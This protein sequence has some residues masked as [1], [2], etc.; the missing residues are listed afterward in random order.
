LGVKYEQQ[1]FKVTPYSSILGNEL[2]HEGK[3]WVSHYGYLFDFG[4]VKVY[5]SGDLSKEATDSYSGLLTEVSLSSPDIAIFPIVGDI[6]NRIPEDA[7][8]FVQAVKASIA[9]PSHYDCFSDRTIDPSIY[10]KLCQESGID[11]IS[12][13]YKGV[14]I[15]RSK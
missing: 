6:P 7:W 9:I 13:D 10:I 8:K 4:F 12:I 2:D 5:N 15:H 1:D 3:P 11:A 14:Y